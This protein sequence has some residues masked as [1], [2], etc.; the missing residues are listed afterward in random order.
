MSSLLISSLIS[1]SIFSEKNVSN[2]KAAR[3][4]MLIRFLFVI[5]FFAVARRGA[6]NFLNS[7]LIN[8]IKN[9]LNVFDSYPYGSSF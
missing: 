5:I 1:A 6:P 3:A 7:E 8:G 4:S 9:S 2:D